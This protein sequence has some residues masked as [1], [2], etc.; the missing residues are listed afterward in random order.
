MITGC[1]A[2]GAGSV[3][4]GGLNMLANTPPNITTNIIEMTMHAMQA[5]MMANMTGTVN[6]DLCFCISSFEKFQNYYNLDNI[7]TQ[8]CPV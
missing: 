2:G 5:P 8:S 6:F 4:T 1:G 3:G 7:T